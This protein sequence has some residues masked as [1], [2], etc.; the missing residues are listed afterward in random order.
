MEARVEAPQRD[1]FVSYSARDESWAKAA[2]AALEK[3]GMRCWI[4]PRDIRGGAT[5]A[6]SIVEAI[7]SCRVM[8]L[9]FSQSA[10][11]SAQVTRELAQAADHGRAVL[12]LRIE[13]VTPSSDKAY[14][15]SGAHWLDAF[16]G[17]RDVALARLVAD[18]RA[19]LDTRPVGSA[20][21]ARPA[22]VRA[23]RADA[24]GEN[25][26]WKR[27]PWFF[28]AALLGLCAVV[29]WIVP[30]F[31]PEERAAHAEAEGRQ[32]ELPAGERSDEE[33]GSKPEPQ[34][35]LQS[36]PEPKI[37]AAAPDPTPP[38]PWGDAPERMRSAFVSIGPLGADRGRDLP[39]RIR[40]RT[41]GIELLYVPGGRFELG[42]PPESWRLAKGMLDSDEHPTRNI[43]M[44]GFYMAVFETTEGEWGGDPS[45]SRLPV[46]DVRHEDVA[47][48]CSE[49]GLL[50]P[51]EA[52][53]EYAASGSE[54]REFP[55]GDEWSPDRCN[56]IGV[57]TKDR[58][59]QAAPVG[60]C[61]EAGQ[62]WCGVQDLAGNVYEWCRWRYAERYAELRGDIDPEGPESGFQNVARGGSWNDRQRNCRT[63]DRRAFAPHVA[64]GYIGFRC[65]YEP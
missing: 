65:V 2:L 61:G 25:R 13:R 46:T 48:W 58:W 32:D 42:T 45:G 41:T 60:S 44:S 53:W 37:E 7:Q 57:G 23:E 26:G 54:N 5:W 30:L 43:T 56:A 18:A 22:Q 10:N 64:N 36:A 17:K 12:P 59:S 11:E 1:V 3:D 47:L 28:A 39:T 50:L 38:D 9:I 19:A 20:P 35:V 63:G 21:P 8:V 31:F 33:R 55:W 29:A 27:G 62:S 49:R 52:Q 34:L 51:T 6:G 14:Y 4:A 16:D 40:H 15:L 24:R